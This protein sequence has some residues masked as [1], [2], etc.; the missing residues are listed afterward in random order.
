MTQKDSENDEFP[1]KERPNYQERNDGRLDLTLH[2]VIDVP[3]SLIWKIWTDP[4]H[5]KKWWAPRPWSTVDCTMDLRPGGILAT[6]MRSPE[7]QDFPYVG[8]FLE[9]VPEEKL[10]WTNALEP[11]YRPAVEPFF[12]AILTL[13][14]VGGKT[15]YT[16]LVMHRDEE[17]RKKHEVMGFHQGWGTVL[18]QLVEVA[19]ELKR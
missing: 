6:T 14:D 17:G 11:G 3:R 2:R 9:I 12:T 15:D 8:C 7:G 19:K 10:V 5:I 18:D 16:A 1:L 4:E 13:K